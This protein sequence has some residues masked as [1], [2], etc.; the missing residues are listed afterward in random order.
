M[1]DA[2]WHHSSI[3]KKIESVL[4]E[5]L[6]LKKVKRDSLGMLIKDIVSK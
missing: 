3:L 4:Q 2:K 5:I 1:L 6:F